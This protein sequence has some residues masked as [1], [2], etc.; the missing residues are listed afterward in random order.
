MKIS[1]QKIFAAVVAVSSFFFLFQNCAPAKINSSESEAAIL[2]NVDQ[3]SSAPP[4]AMPAPVSTPAPTPAP[5]PVPAPAISVSTTLINFGNVALGSTSPT[6]FVTITNTGSA[7]LR[8]TSKSFSMTY[9]REDF[10]TST[11]QSR[12]NPGLSCRIGI[13]FDADIEQSVTAI[14]RIDTN[15]ANSPTLIQLQG[16]GYF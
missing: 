1:Q 15:V 6:K 10:F 11:C 2:N 9:F 3:G 4:S 5:T 7:E 14:F 13:V 16:T 12:L 8:I